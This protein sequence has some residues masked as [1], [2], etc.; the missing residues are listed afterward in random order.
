M[1]LHMR[2]SLLAFG[3]GAAFSSA[4][5]IAV[6]AAITNEPR[7]SQQVARDR[8]ARR[9]HSLVRPPLPFH[10]CDACHHVPLRPYANSC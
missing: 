5:L 6:A 8:R 1:L 4:V 2:S 10:P 9:L 3:T 7:R